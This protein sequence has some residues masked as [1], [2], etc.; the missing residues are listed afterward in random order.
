MIFNWYR[1]YF[2]GDQNVLKLY[3][4]D[5]LIMLSILKFTEVCTITVFLHRVFFL[6]DK[7]IF[8][9]HSKITQ[10]Q[11]ISKK[12]YIFSLLFWVK[13]FLIPATFFF[14]LIVSKSF[15]NS[16]QV[17]QKLLWSSRIEHKLVV[18][19]LL[20]NPFKRTPK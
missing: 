6:W 14:F 15:K 12:A 10:N 4:G 5:G 7:G 16:S 17:F 13:L 18:I 20:L 19:S 11:R 1:I 3:V 8:T 2:G 9:N